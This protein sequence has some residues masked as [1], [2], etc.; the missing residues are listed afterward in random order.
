MQR[1]KSA[2]TALAVGIVLLTALDFAAAAATGRGMV[3][4]HWNQ[5]DHK[6]VLKNTKQGVA[7]DLRAKNGPVLKVNNS[8]RIKKLN[9]DKVDGMTGARLQDQ[10]QHHLP[11]G[12]R[13]PHRR[14]QPGA[15]DRRPPA[16][17]WSPTRSSSPAP[18]ATR[19]T[20]T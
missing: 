15:P 3:L 7:L 5:A 17:T 8:K 13:Q 10:P 18:P 14:L 4:G 2:L 20:P 16:A 11:V 9:A 1:L 19:P 6:T 12:H